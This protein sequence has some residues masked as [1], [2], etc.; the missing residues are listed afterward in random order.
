MQL[1]EVAQAALCLPLPGVMYPA[2][3]MQTHAPYAWLFTKRACQ[4]KGFQ[5]ANGGRKKA[6]VVAAAS[7][8]N[9]T[10]RMNRNA[11]EFAPCSVAQEPPG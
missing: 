3:C 5:R 6:A 4:K 10:G 7:G 8:I 9:V 1:H 2:I 11:R